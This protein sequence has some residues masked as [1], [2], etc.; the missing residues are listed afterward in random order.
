MAQTGRERTRD[1]GLYGSAV[2]AA[3]WQRGSASR[4][5]LRPIT[6]RMLDLAGIRAGHRVLDVA[7]GTGAVCSNWNASPSMPRFAVWR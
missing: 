7:A 2:A 3:G 4:A 1:G 6:D 5:D